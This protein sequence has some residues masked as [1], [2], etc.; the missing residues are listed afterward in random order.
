MGRIYYLTPATAGFLASV[1]ALHIEKAGRRS[2]LAAY[3]AM[4]AVEGLFCSLVEAGKVLPIKNGE[5][6]IFMLSMMWLSSLEP[7]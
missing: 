4:L 2:A 1:C 7:Q 3:V 5:T 6:M